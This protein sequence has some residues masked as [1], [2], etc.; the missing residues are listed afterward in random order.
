MIW[1]L[2]CKKDGLLLANMVCMLAG[3]TPE[4]MQFKTTVMTSVRIGSI[5]EKKEIGL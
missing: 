4:K 5:V 1:R 2:Y 3:G